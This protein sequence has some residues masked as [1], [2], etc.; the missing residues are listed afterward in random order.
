MTWR[1]ESVDQFLKDGTVPR[2]PVSVTQMADFA[3]LIWMITPYDT[4]FLTEGP[5]E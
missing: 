4:P 3:D 5:G 2:R 1:A